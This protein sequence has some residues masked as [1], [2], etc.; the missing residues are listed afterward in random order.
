[1][2]NYNLAISFQWIFDIDFIELTERIF[3]QDGLTTFIIGKYNINEVTEDIRNRKIS[4]DFYLDRASDVDSDFEPLVKIL[5]KKKTYLIN[6]YSKVKKAIVKAEM[7]DRLIE[8]GHSVPDTIILKPFDQNPLLPLSEQD[9][10]KIGI[11]FVIKPSFYTGGGDG[12]VVDAQTL[13]Q[14]HEARLQYTDDHFLVQRKIF[15]RIFNGRRAW[16]RVFYA[17]GKVIP[18]WW[19]D[20]THIYH[21]FKP[22]EVK[23]LKLDKLQKIVIKIAKIV[24]LDYFSTEI[25]LTEDNEFILIDY[26]NDQCDMRLKK[27][28]FDGVPDDVVQ[29]FILA[30]KSFIKKHQ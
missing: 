16:F 3:Q 30:M 1:M 9:L 8:Q 2:K 25:A 10:T 11:P 24:D 6:P 13:H 21:S 29:K 14:V 4:F 15:P 17:F 26:V 23:E 22:H 7:H 28:H 20:T 27:H 12:V 19:D 5:K 18:V